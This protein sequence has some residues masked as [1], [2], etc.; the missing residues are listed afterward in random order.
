MAVN[1]EAAAATAAARRLAAPALRKGYTPA[2]LHV[3]RDA[4]GHPQFWR[5]RC[6]DPQTGDKW[7]RPMH[8]RSGRFLL[9][10]PPAPESGKLLYRVPEILQAD[11][12]STIVIVEGETCADALARIGIEATTSGSADSCSAADWGPVRNRRCVIWPDN[13]TAG[14]RYGDDVARTLSKLGCDVR[15]IEVEHLGLP[16]KGDCVDWLAQNPSA[17]V[18]QILALPTRSYST[19]E[20]YGSLELI[21]ASDVTCTP[22]RWIWSGW[23]AAGKLHILAGAPGTGKTTIALAISAAVSSATTLPDGSCPPRG[24]VVIWSGEDGFDDTLAPR[25]KFAG[26]DMSAIYFVGKILGDGERRPFDPATD[27]VFLEEKIRALGGVSM[28]VID[29][30]V[31]A[32]AGDSH[33]NTEVRRALQP[34]VDLA[35]NLG[36][37]VLGISHFSKSSVGRDPIERV[38][39]SIAFGA[40]ARVV[41]VTA[42]TN[43]DDENNGW[44]L[45]T[46]AKSNIGVDG[47]GF[48][49]RLD[50]CEQDTLEAARIIWGNPLNGSARQLLARVETDPAEQSSA[51]DD[52]KEWLIAQLA[53]G[54]KPTNEIRKVASESG[55]AWRTIERAKAT[56]N[57]Q[58]NRTGA[59][60]GWLWSMPL[61]TKNEGRQDRQENDVT[62]DGGLGGLGSDD[63]TA[64]DPNR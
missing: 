38:T 28:L 21:C 41:M 23:L 4:T 51:R 63:V 32:V 44:R 3:Y 42:S 58:A 11:T 61:S 13:D 50:R 31:S 5:I 64:E 2:G 12:G 20:L 36:I 26:A 25:L 19:A 56:L 6:R 55:F 9:G 54:P 10:E 53:A 62:H 15:I 43:N 34:L 14:A 24:R 29:P 17:T 35:S 27:M 57:I 1:I 22:V 39:G 52:A 60:G 18:E 37:A 59:D 16:E 8:Y 7:I 49:Y 48:E 46:R 47:G 45:L 30:V 33:R 40:L